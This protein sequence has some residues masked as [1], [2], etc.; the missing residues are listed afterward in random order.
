MKFRKP[1]GLCS[2]GGSLSSFCQMGAALGFAS[3]SHFK[4]IGMPSRTGKP[5]PGSRDMANEGV[6]ENERVV[7]NFCSR[8]LI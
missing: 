6:S 7:G 4:D 5:K 8:T 2:T 1:S 3:T